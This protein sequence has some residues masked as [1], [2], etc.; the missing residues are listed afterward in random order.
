M[1]FLV[2]GK[3]VRSATTFIGHLPIW[4]SVRRRPVL[5]LVVCGGIVVATVIVAAGFV[6]ANLRE[7]ALAD[8]ERELKN[9]AFVLAEEIDRA[10]QA[11]ELLQAGLIEH[12]YAVG[13]QLP[14]EFEWH[15]ADESVHTML[16]ERLASFPYIDVLSV[17]DSQG[18]VV[19]FSREW[20]IPQLSVADR[21]YFKALQSDPALDSYLSEPLPNRNA[22]TWTIYLS[23][24]VRG[25]KGE[26]LGLVTGAMQLRHFEALFSRIALGADRGIGL[27][28]RDGILL[29]RYPHV[30]SMGKSFASNK[31]FAEL[32]QGP[33]SRVI[34]QAG[35]V[36]EQDRL[37]AATSLAHYQAVVTASASVAGILADWGTEA[38]YLIGLVGA[39]VL[40][41]GGTGVVVVQRFREQNMQLDAALNNMRQG[42]LMFD[43]ENRLLVVNQRYI[44]MYR[45]SPEDVR[46]GCTARDLLAWRLANGT[47]SGDIDQYLDAQGGGE[48]VDSASELPDG[49]TIQVIN[50][51]MADG[52]WVSTHSDITEQRK[53]EFALVAAR[54]AAEEAEQ[55]ARAAHARLLDAFEVVPEGVVL[56]DAEDRY[57]MWNR[58]YA[59]L[60]AFTGI[61]LVPGLRFD[62]MLRGGLARG[63]YPDAAGR[64]EEWLAER[65]AAHLRSNAT[66]EQR[67]PDGRWLKICERR[68]T[69]GGSVGVRIDI[70]E[71]KRREAS[72]RLLFD[73][74]P[75][76]MWVYENASL[77][78]VAVN[79]AAVEHYGYSRPQFLAMTLRDITSAEGYDELRDL[80][81]AASAADQRGRTWRHLKA[82][83]KEIDVTV[84]SQ[85]LLYEGHTASIGVAV[86]VTERKVAEMKV[87]RARE[88]LDTVIDNIPATIL[89]KDA[90]DLRY[91]LV[92]RAAEAL[93]GLPRAEIIGKEA[94]AIFPGAT[95]D[96]FMTD[97][98]RTLIGGNT[99]V[100]AHEIPTPKNGVRLVTSSKL[101]ILN[102]NGTPDYLLT[103]VDDITERRRAEEKIAHLVHHDPLTDLPNRSAFNGR[104]AAM[105]DRSAA[106][107]RTFALLSV[108]LDRF[109]EIN[110]VFGHSIGDSLLQE[111]ARRL[112]GA[113]KGAFIARVG[114]DE[115]AII[116]EGEQPSGAEALSESL[117]AAVASDI[118]I[119]GHQLQVGLSIGVAIYPDDGANAETLI[120]NADAALFRTKADGRGTIRFFDGETDKR[121][122]DRR[123]L[124]NELR[125][126]A[127]RGELV[128]HYQ[129]QARISNGEIVGFEALVRWRHPVRG[130][131]PPD[132]F[133]VLAEQSGLILSVGESILREACREAASWDKPLLIAVNLSPV[134]FQG[135]D[136]PGLV[137]SI[138]L[139][140]GLSPARL[141]LEITETAFIN[142]FSRAA[143][144]L[145]QLK[146]LG[147]KITI[148]DFGVG[149]SSMSSL[150]AL[151]FDKIKIDKTFMSNVDCN[152]QSAAIVRAVIGLGRG[153]GLPVLAE[154]VETK[155]Q[156]AFLEREGCDEVQGYLLGRPCPIEDY[157]EAVG[158]A[159]PMAQTKR[160]AE[161]IAS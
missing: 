69:D 82:D 64:E 26:F 107:E 63:Q 18:K 120:A 88:F 154:G 29:A 75:L 8:A 65:M 117:H 101:A 109:K 102:E 12:M 80:G 140:T 22:G 34:R 134:Q 57:V 10:F 30:D 157:A 78:F 93:L 38:R 94:S 48:H 146:S 132:S 3:V 147:V 116:A 106:S 129:P 160:A 131:L 123:A 73:S 51:P 105:L 138:L 126:A 21:D 128:L 145:R 52:S 77:R 89:V 122:R 33:G 144:I 2:L 50:K 127:A 15:N 67:L 110:D 118:D 95:A 152:A 46:P 59:E 76:P 150:Q 68:T 124:Q 156:L 159:R 9:T 113:A 81:V 103:V 84:F 23:R 155:E 4:R 112:Q 143:S 20:P 44:E 35:I 40:V 54:A 125:S 47:F 100:D 104:L 24:K 149:Y 79:D 37:I 151:P 97:D 14:E 83:R 13:V 28:R 98:W 96:Q 49:R 71:L 19:N 56:F 121:L 74:N 90:H 135:G 36:S 115:F 87:R 5:S 31:A 53:A 32:L 108:D 139:E 39:L 1:G 43:K 66:H 61:E 137:H 133:I 114:G 58:R 86:D 92:N 11:V 16:K 17:V 158:R 25:P 27:F 7:R 142:D 141:E 42:L 91:I 148:D 130:L 119:H 55:Q 153:L 45:L 41:I 6:L 161:A 111:V 72:F 60:Y 99:F 85:P 70:T 136:I 62:D